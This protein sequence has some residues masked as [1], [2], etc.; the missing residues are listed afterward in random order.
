MTTTLPV[1]ALLR[2]GRIVAIRRL[3]PADEP[4]AVHFHQDLSEQNTYLRF[5]HVPHDHGAEIG[6]RMCRDED[7]TGAALGAWL[8]PDLVGVAQY[9]VVGGGDADVAFAVADKAHRLGLATLLLE[10]LAALARLAGVG[11]FV[12]DVLA[13]NRD[14]LRVFADAGLP[15]LR[16]SDLHTVGVSMELAAGERYA[17]A[18]LARDRQ[19]QAASLRHVLNPVSVA[20]VGASP[21]PGS[22]G[23]SVLA[24]LRRAGYPGNLAAIHPTATDVGGTPAYRS[25]ADVPFTPELAV[26]AVPA[27]AL[28]AAIDDCGQ[29]GVRAVVV[30]TAGLDRAAGAALRDTCRGYG[31]RLVGPNCLGVANP[32]AHLDAT[33][34]AHPALAGQVGLAVQ[35]GGIGIALTEQLSRLGI[36]VS[37]FTSLGDKY[38]VSATDLLQW[39][40]GDPDTRQAVLYV[41]SFGNPRRF[42]RVAAEVGRKIPVLAVDAGRSAPAQSA[43]QSHT[44]AAAT[45][46]ATR[47]ALFAQ[48]GIIAL[49]DLADLVG[50]SALLAWQPYPAGRGVA[51]VSN[52]GGAGILAAD[53]CADAGLD[54]PELAAATARQLAELLPTGAATHNPVDATAG[55]SP[56]QLVRAAEILAAD[57]AVDAVLVLP[58]PTAQHDMAEITWADL[59]ITQI[60]I[61]LDAAE[62][63]AGQAAIPRGGSSSGSLVPVY[64]SARDAAV[65]LARV[66]AYA[67]WRRRTEQAPVILAG[68]ARGRVREVVRRF[69][70]AHPEGG[71]LAPD[72]AV[73]LVEAAGVPTV[74]VRVARSA[75]EAAV[76][77]DGAGYPVAVKAIAHGTVHKHHARGVA[78]GLRDS[79]AVAAAYRDF[80]ARFGAD[81]TGV[82][83][84]PMA[85]GDL[86]LLA[87]AYSDPVFGPVVAYGLGGTEADAL[88]DKQVR[89]APLSEV[90][91]A[92][93]VAGI[94]AA[95]AYEHAAGGRPVDVAALRAVVTAVAA[96]AEAVPELAELDLNP[97][98]ATAGGARAVDAKARLVPVR[99]YDPYLRSLR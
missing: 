40:H 61:R 3:T 82:L 1:W 12:A 23:G 66:A 4:A 15:V 68:P 49:A 70:A 14:M 79:A 9:E 42:A 41:E 22:T 60:A 25:V 47:E 84:Q 7:G 74:P 69:L 59:G 11:R 55:A 44:A 5:F 98:L 10:H 36:G 89:L 78:L 85:H 53:A 81:L 99:P 37:S 76:A 58:V 56:E 63:V 18:V 35:S 16:H 8:G 46:A 62:R 34:A 73:R 13:E 6:R 38:D 50:T 94:R 90:D 95:G 30:L 17:E 2:D 91:A 54:V 48:A 67:A 28:A 71:W 26:I 72:E 87:G 39:W 93:M 97:V 43:A 32:H 19:A 45:P 31:M 86:E 88:A 77:A 80:A 83:V 96:L 24:N 33:F 65:A 27:G 20:V 29:A 21:R 52:A 51:I 75:G 92:A 64:A 57:P